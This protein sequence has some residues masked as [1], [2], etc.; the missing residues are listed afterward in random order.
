K[1]MTQESLRQLRTWMAEQ[2]LDAFMVSQPQNRS[3]VSGWLNDDAESGGLLLVG[4]QQQLLFTTPLYKEVAENQA[5]GWQINL[6]TAREYAPVI[7]TAAQE[8]GW[9]KIGFE[10][11]TVTYSEYDKLRS[12]SEGIFTLQPVEDS[13]VD[14]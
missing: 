5:H 14:D 2:G 13:F 7:V 12:A 3:Y 4:Q 8:H 10:S 1:S 6:P 11:T 9:R